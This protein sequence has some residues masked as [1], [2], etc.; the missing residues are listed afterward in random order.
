MLKFLSTALV[1]LLLLVWSSSLVGSDIENSKSASAFD[2]LIVLERPAASKSLAACAMQKHSDTAVGFFSGFASGDRNVTYFDPSVECGGLVY[3]YQIQA[4]SFTLFDGGGYQWPVDIDVVVYDLL[5]TDSCGGPGSELCRFTVQCDSS[6]FALPNV[7]TVSFPFTCCMTGPFYIGL[8]YSDTGAGPFPSIVFDNS[9]PVPTCDNWGF[10]GGSWFEWYDFWAGPNFPGYPIFWID[11]ETQSVACDANVMLDEV[12]P[13]TGNSGVGD[14]LYSVV[15]ISNTGFDSLDLTGW[16]IAGPN[17]GEVI[18]LPSWTIPPQSYLRVEFGPGTDD[19]DFSD[20]MAVYFSGDTPWQFEHTGDEVGLYDGI[21]IVDFVGWGHGSST[22]GDAYNDAVGAGIWTGGDYVDITS[23]SLLGMLARTPSGYD[24]DTPLDWRMS[25]MSYGTQFNFH[26]PVQNSPRHGF[27][28]DSTPT[29]LW[30]QVGSGD[31]GVLLQIDNDS[32][33]VSP[34]VSVFTSDTTFDTTLADDTYYWRILPSNA[35]GPFPAAVWEFTVD[36]SLPARTPKISGG[37]AALD[38]GSSPVPQKFQHKESKLLCIWNLSAST[39]PGCTEAASANGPWDNDHQQGNHIPGCNHCN[40]YCTRASIQMVNHRYTGSLK[41]DEISY[42]MKENNVAGPEGDLGHGVGAWPSEDSTYSWAMNNAAIAENFINPDAAIPWATFKAEIDANRPVLAVIRP[43][44]W[45]HTVVFDSYFQSNA[46]RRWIY[47]SDPWPGRTGWYR[48]AIMPVVRYYIL[49]ANP[50]G[51][52]TEPNVSAD[53]DGDGVMD[54]DEQQ[55]GASQQVARPFHS[56]HNDK[57][58][59]DDQVDDKPEIRNYTF[60]D[61]IGYHQGHENDPLGFPDIDGDNFRAEND[62]DSDNDSDFDGGEDINGNGNNPVPNAGNVCNR[63]TCQFDLNEFCIKVAVDKDVYLLGEPVFIVDQH[64]TRETHTYHENST[65]NY[66]KGAGC[67][68]KADSSA[69]FHS[70]SFSTDGGGHAIPTLV[71]YCLTPGVKY[72]TVDVLD[73]NLY[74]TP[75]NL[76]PQTC[77][78]C[79]IDWFHGFHWGF[80]YFPYHNPDSGSIYPNYDYPVTYSTPT[81]N[82]TV[83]TYTITCPWWWWCFEWPPILDN[84][85]LGVGLPADLVASGDIGFDSASFP[86]LVE[87]LEGDSLG[88]IYNQYIPTEIVSLDLTS[89]FP[90]DNVQWFGFEIPS[91]QLPDS[92]VSTRVEI[93]VKIGHKTAVSPTVIIM[94]GDSEFGWSPTPYDSIP[95]TVLPGGCCVGNRG[96]VNGDGDD[97]NILDLTYLVDRIFRGGPPA[98]CPEEADLN[99]DGS[100]SNIIDLTFLV[101]RIFR[102]G[103]APGPC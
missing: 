40:V 11:G 68:A 75:D 36:S 61:Q 8:E 57:D 9:A 99:S 25:E 38:F 66:E 56:V 39:R 74:S 77:W 87:S 20:G 37:A 78:T 51:R 84:Y 1:F 85:W 79:E 48:H 7:A 63:E 89:S 5:G 14:S 60:H 91:W 2:E 32:L 47:I 69:L 43:P 6:L 64:Y 30:H 80:D 82:P 50:S 97:A 62:C 95:I 16:E 53:S 70:G 94:A 72:L 34:E 3:P 76:D 10:G 71:E 55:P 73:D 28:L 102:G 17:T 59:D 31:A 18:T 4:I 83:V 86:L 23:G 24:N 81:E 44:G 26:N 49:P 41:Q 90:L 92:L 96:D 65:Y 103:I 45:F 42:H 35:G 101:D 33:F 29:L 13:W 15:E 67:P 46:G 22:F 100:S 98:V 12:R 27:L 52:N 19:P 58:T 88:I 21:A 54:F 93:K